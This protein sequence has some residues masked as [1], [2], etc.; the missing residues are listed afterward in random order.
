MQMQYNASY[1][2][3]LNDIN[4]QQKTSWFL[5]QSEPRFTVH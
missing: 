2:M 1:V 4:H 5:G 3:K